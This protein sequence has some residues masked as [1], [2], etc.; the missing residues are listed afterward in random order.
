MTVLCMQILSSSIL[1]PVSLTTM[2]SGRNTQA[3]DI[4]VY[5]A[6]NA[7]SSAAPNA[8]SAK[9]ITLFLH[10][11][12]GLLPASHTLEVPRSYRTATGT[13]SAETVTPGGQHIPVAVRPAKLNLK[14]PG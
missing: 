13:N 10:Q 8:H 9:P 2:N 7:L 11:P 5:L 3:G 14:Q 12:D 4:Q 6:D 1:D